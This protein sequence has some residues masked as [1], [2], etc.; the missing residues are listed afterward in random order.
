MNDFF[1]IGVENKPLERY[2][3][4]NLGAG[5]INEIFF[6]KTR[7]S[8]GGIGRSAFHQSVTSENYDALF[9]SEF[10]KIKPPYEGENF[11]NYHLEYYLEKGGDKDKFIKHMK[12]VILPRMQKMYESNVYVEVLK[13]W[14]KEKSQ[15]RNMAQ[16]QSSTVISGS[17][18]IVNLAGG[19][20]HQ[21]SVA[22]NVTSNQY[23]ELKDLGVEEKQISELKEIVSENKNDKPTLKSKLF[24]WLGAVTV[25]VAS[26][27]LSDNLPTIQE[28]VH[29]L[30]T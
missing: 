4:R 20:I 11:L 7:Q 1:S 12:F 22:I 15:L 8:G 16:K 19:D 18:N 26:K 3:L 27:G 23:N 13:S 17:N 9:S 30:I 10:S 6:S 2:Q 28:F 25:S 29:N 24:K 14:I 21:N 5:I